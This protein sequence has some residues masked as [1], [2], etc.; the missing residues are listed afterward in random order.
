MSEA[1]ELQRQ[2]PQPLARHV[3]RDPLDML[4]TMIERG[5]TTENAAAFEQLVKLS[6]HMEDRRAEKEFAEAFKALQSETGRVKAM[7][8]VYCKDKTLKYKF[9]PYEAIMEQVKPMLEKHGFTVTFS[10][11]FGEGRLIKVCTLQHVGGHSRS[12]K[13]A[14]RIGSGPPGCSDSQADGAAS[15]YAKRFA[16]CDA[17]NITIEKDSDAAVEGDVITAEQ[18]K[19]LKERVMATG[20]NEEFF[21][22]FAGA[23][24]YEDIR[25]SKYAVLDQNL[26]KKEKTA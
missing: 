22:Q 25:A 12:N 9:A 19:S 16:L 5:V 17:L 6:E 8:P 2:E 15:T 14:V 20:S 13:F 23:G 21:L 26:R 1:L 24:R 11:E 3:S 10:T 7:Q 18:A 4:Q